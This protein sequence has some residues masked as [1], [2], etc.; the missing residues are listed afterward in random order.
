MYR[1]IDRTTSPSPRRRA[2]ATAARA[3]LLA[4]SVLAAA[5]GEDAVDAG[6][7]AMPA[8]TGPLYA[9][10]TT[11]FLPDGLLSL[12]ALVEDPGAPGTLDPAQALEVGGAASIYGMDGQGAFAVGSSESPVITRYEV[13]ADGSLVEGERLSLANLGVSA[14]FKREGLVPVLSETKAYWLDDTTQQGVVWNPQEMV[15]DGSFSLA[16]AAREGFELE[17]GERAVLRDD[18]L[19]FVGARYRTADDGEAGTAAALVI[20]TATDELL[21]VIEDTRCGDTVHIVAAADG[22][23]Y[24]GSGAVAAVLHALQRPVDYPAPCLLRVLPGEQGF[25]PDFHAVI[26]DLVEGRT[27]GRLVAG[28]DG[29][30]YLLALHEEELGIELG[31]TTEIW[32]P[33]DAVAWRWWRLELGASTSAT[34]VEGTPLA[35]AAGHV[36]FADGQDY[37]TNV[38]VDDGVTTLLV[39][40]DDGALQA[41]L[42]APGLPYGLVRVR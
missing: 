17:L 42:E 27:A 22:T 24:F 20:D 36:L 16:A 30:A 2:H 28:A 31:P 10:A 9:V 32:E 21:E 35:S 39:A 19:L 4:A 25:D 34:L 38:R 3:C 14:A 18:G 29:S 23:L 6:A 12:V 40:G 7:D 37:I 8:A 41:G 13:A 1:E 26:P 11:Q 5:C 33:W 15:I